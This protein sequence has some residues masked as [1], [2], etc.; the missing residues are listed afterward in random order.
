[1]YRVQPDAPVPAWVHG[2]ASFRRSHLSGRKFGI[3]NL[4]Q[5]I[6]EATVPCLTFATLLKRHGIQ[7]V[8]LLQIDTE[9][10]D[11]Q[12]VRMAIEAGVY[13]SIIN[14]E[15]VHACPAERAACKRMLA[16]AG[17]QFY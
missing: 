10:F 16:E 5:F 15:F 1:M 3:R 14:Y 13:P 9:G 12:I 6:E 8:T 11:C 7:K 2:L 17:L 4:D